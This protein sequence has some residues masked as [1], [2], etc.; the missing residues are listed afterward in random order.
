MAIAMNIRM[1]TEMRI[2]RKSTSIIETNSEQ[3]EIPIEHLV[4]GK[5]NDWFVLGNV[6]V[7]LVC[8]GIL[9]AAL[10]VVALIT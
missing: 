3:R 4:D 5:V 9:P 1:M 2:P 7:L 10:I 8:L 6:L